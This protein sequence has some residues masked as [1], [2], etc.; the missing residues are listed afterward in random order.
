MEPNIIIRPIEQKDS[1]AVAHLIRTVMTEFGAVGEGYSIMDP[2]LEDMYTAYLPEHSLFLV[3]ESEGN[4]LGC[5][6]IAP[7]KGAAAH[8]C[9]LR[10][11]YFYSELR[12]KGWG[13]KIMDACMTA[14]KER[15]YKQCYLETISSMATARILYEKVGFKAIPSPIGNTGHSSCQL[16]YLLNL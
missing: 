8:I 11:M 12:G 9:E 15:N 5:A 2:E 1:L 10:K 3:I 6:G 13:R 14:A 16:F 4:I 7:L